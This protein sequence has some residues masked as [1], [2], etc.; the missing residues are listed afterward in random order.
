MIRRLLLGLAG[1]VLVVIVI[2]LVRTVLLEPRWADIAPVT[3]SRIDEMAAAKRLS[4]SVTFATVSRNL[5]M[6]IDAQAFLG[7]HDFLAR[8]YPLVHGAL[9]REVINDYSLVYTW[10]GSEPALPPILLMG[11]LDVVPADGTA[12]WE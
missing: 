1:I 5:E 7:L 2:V 9:T 11:H 3:D 10:Q 6:A 4:E 8:S 12:D